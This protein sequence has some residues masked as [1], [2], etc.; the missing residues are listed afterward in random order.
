MGTHHEGTA[1]ER[2]ALDAYIKL[3]RAARS[4]TA[5]LVRRLATE[6]L[7]ERQFGVLETLYHL[8]PLPQCALG[9]K[10]LTTGGNITFVV[11]NLV[12]DGLAE[13]RRD[14]SDRR[15]VT[16]H[17]TP[18]GRAL[19]AQTFPRHAAAI[20][21]QFSALTPDEQ[22]VLARLMKKLGLAQGLADDEGAETP[23]TGRA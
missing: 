8:G 2:R 4:V 3:M 13:R 10:Q 5:R 14:S 23:A 19:I 9:R 17:L 18:K 16:V 7:T 11:D 20:Q 22:E 1:A 12:R 15:I 21:E 6:R